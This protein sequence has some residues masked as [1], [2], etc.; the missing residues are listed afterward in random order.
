MIYIFLQFD[1]FYKNA[2]IYFEKR[3]GYNHEDKKIKFKRKHY[4]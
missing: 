4:S 3:K 1:K 2:I